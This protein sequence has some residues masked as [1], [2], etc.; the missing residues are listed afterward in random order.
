METGRKDDS[1]KLRFDLLPFSALKEVAG[2]IT[3]GAGKYGAENWQKVSNLESRYFAAALRH[4]TE[5]AIG[6]DIDPESGY[7]HLAHAICSLM[8]VL[9]YELEQCDGD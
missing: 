4:L 2:V 5:Y 3:F 6:E 8:F 7:R 9:E 1:G